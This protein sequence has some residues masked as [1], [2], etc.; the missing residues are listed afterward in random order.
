MLVLNLL[1][2]LSLA[3]G[4]EYLAPNDIETHDSR[5]ILWD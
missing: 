1:T 2:K 5:N 3:Q 4:L